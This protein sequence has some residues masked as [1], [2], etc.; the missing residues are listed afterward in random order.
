MGSAPHCVPC[1]YDQ[2][3]PLHQRWRQYIGGL[4][5]GAGAGAK[6]AGAGSSQQGSAAGTAAEAALLL[7]ADM[8]GCMLRVVDCREGRWRGL[9]GVVVRDTQ[10]T[11]VLVNSESRLVTVPKRGSVFEFDL[12]RGRVVRL[13]NLAPAPQSAGRKK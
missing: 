11:F 3:L 2:V 8:H 13:A 1:R 4:L 7:D 12:G 6:P 5:G 9:E 10:Q